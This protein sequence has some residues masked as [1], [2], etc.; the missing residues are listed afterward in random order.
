MKLS[1]LHIK[2]KAIHALILISLF[3]SISIPFYSELNNR[4]NA[5]QT[6]LE[7]YKSS[8]ESAISRYKYLPFILSQD[9]KLVDIV[10]KPS[11]LATTGLFLQRIK[12]A[13]N[14]ST[15]YIL[16]AD[17]NTIASSN[18]DSETSYI[19]NNYSFR[20]YF[21]DAMAGRLG[22]FY[23]IGRT[24]RAPGFFISY[25]LKSDETIIG[26]VTIEL[27]LSDL[28]RVWRSGPDEI[29]VSDINNIIF[30]SSNP[31]WKNK[32]FGS[33]SPNAMDKVDSSKQF[34]MNLLVPASIKQ[35][36]RTRNFQFYSGET[37]GCA[38]PARLAFEGQII[39]FGWKITSF[40]STTY[41]YAALAIITTLTLLLYAIIVFSYRYVK[42]RQ[43]RREQKLRN[44]LV[45]ND[46]LASIG[47]MAT[48]LAHEFNQPL[49]AIYMLLDTTRLML[50]RKMYGDANENLVL[51]SGHIERMTQQISELK[52]FASRHRVPNGD[53]DIVK[54]ANRSLK[55]FQIML[56]RNAIDLTFQTSDDELHIPCN[57]IG[58]EQIF[59]NLITNAVEELDGQEE[60]T[61]Q[62]F[63]HKGKSDGCL[64]LSR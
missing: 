2:K 24:T 35:C 48:E 7:M 18:W 37:F 54:V 45:E 42:A 8:L 21:K 36:F 27:H 53:A 46:K 63:N 59:N 29:L 6:L 49:S 28:E 61:L 15:V 12:Y 52:S 62:S 1:F 31:D 3:I 13:S 5:S 40:K 9:Q 47:Q 44:K 43:S 33:I 60:K 50:K 41:L 30:L 38:L 26:V 10:T 25:G 58:L 20:P 64:D 34:S 19:G 14:V 17:G 23:G 11:D 22:Q 39:E 51:V 4:L 57:E 56:K 16:D 55:L 32:L